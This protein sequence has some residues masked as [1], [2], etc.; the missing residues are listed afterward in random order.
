MHS[1]VSKGDLG[2]PD[3][4]TGDCDTRPMT[5]V[6]KACA[7]LRDF[8]QVNFVLSILWTHR[9]PARQ[10]LINIEQRNYTPVL[11]ITLISCT[12]YECEYFSYAIDD[13][14]SAIRVR[15]RIA[16]Y[17]CQLFPFPFC[18]YELRIRASQ[19]CVVVQCD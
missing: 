11:Y 15:S 4:W 9:Q 10:V 1:Q 12:R 7:T 18:Q 16:F 5:C 17:L 14:N 6:E 19:R 2:Q 3:L 13:D 8:A